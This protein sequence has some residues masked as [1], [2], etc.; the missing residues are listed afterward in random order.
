MGYAYGGKCFP[1]TSEVL[2]HFK[3][4]FPFTDGNGITYLT[5]AS[6]AAPTGLAYDIRQH[7]FTSSTVL[8]KT[9]SVPLTLCTESAYDRFANV[10]IQDVAI[11][12]GIGICFVV[13][14]LAG[15]M[16]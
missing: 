6:I 12:L 15:K 10:A 14:L 16:R 11:A 1:S 3:S 9:G 2:D 8:T 4:Q 13:G 7:S 5:T